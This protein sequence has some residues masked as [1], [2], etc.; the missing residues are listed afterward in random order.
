MKNGT[1]KTDGQ[2]LA[3]VP[4]F[5]VLALSG[6]GFRGLYTASVL[7]VLEDAL[8]MPLIRRFDL[9]CGT[10]VGGLLALGL[11]AGVPASE[12]QDMFVKNGRRIFGTS[13]WW[14]RWLFGKW[15]FAK[16][17]S[18]G[19][20]AVLTE[21]FGNTTMGDL[22]QR[23]VIPAV[24]YTTGKSQFFK[25]P[26]SPELERDHNLKL[27]DVA[28]ATSAAPTYFPLHR[29]DGVGV[30]A[31]GGLVGNSPGFFGLHEAA[32]FIRPG[33]DIRVLAIGT[34]TLGST[35]A[36][37][38]LLDRGIAL[39]KERVFDLTISAQESS[40]HYVLKHLLGDRYVRVD[41]LAQ[42]ALVADIRALDRFSVGAVRVL[43]EC[44]AHDA[45]RTLGVAE[46]APFRTHL[47]TAPAFFHGQR[48][49]FER[50]THAEH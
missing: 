41:S 45:Q 21:L 20:S 15:I 24:N 49:A 38:E 30:F 13:E 14:R 17:S 46:F 4:A 47:A 26:H 31:D 28:L 27:V 5:H 39:W 37:S 12:L 35:L 2:Q 50:E 43:R 19:L 48:R 8:G 10:S 33:A 44:G 6:G 7:K 42:G 11:A 18:A 3:T 32:H 25:T 23:V 36:G 40:T 9:I 34:M 29:I 16:H 1:G 22:R